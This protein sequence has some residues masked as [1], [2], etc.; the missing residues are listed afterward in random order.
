MNHQAT[1]EKITQMRLWGIKDAYQAVLEQ[2]TS[3]GNDAFLAHLIEAEWLDRHNRKIE[4]LIRQARFRYT[5]HPSELEYNAQRGLDKNLILRLS[6]CS[7]IKKKE[8]ILITGATG[9]GKS[10]VASALGHQACMMGYKTMYFNTQKL[11]SIL[12]A[13]LADGSYFKWINKIERQQLLILD[14]F[15][16]QL[17]DNHNRQALMEIIED[18]H[19]KHST[20]VLSQLPTNKWHRVIGESAIADAILDRLVHSAHRIELKGES[21]RKRKLKKETTD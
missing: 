9:V 11:F 20:I 7:F 1:L 3:M 16:L 4:R 18:R 17:L 13:A 14:D 6:D 15:G 8:N 10:F 21:M 5:A 12:K 19:N 2:N